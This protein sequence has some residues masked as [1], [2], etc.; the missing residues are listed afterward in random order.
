MH[1]LASLQHSKVVLTRLSTLG[2]LS[3]QTMLSAF[4][5]AFTDWMGNISGSSYKAN[6][7]T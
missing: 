5:E 2:L 3:L 4:A 6:V 1:K 7:W